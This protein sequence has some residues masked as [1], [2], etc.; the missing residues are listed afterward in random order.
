M[1][2]F[3]AVSFLGSRSDFAWISQAI[4]DGTCGLSG[5][6]FFLYI[7]MVLS[8]GVTVV[9]RGDNQPCLKIYLWWSHLPGGTSI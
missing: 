2:A 7:T 6:Y 8:Q 1:N 4:P 9:P 5:S 3:K